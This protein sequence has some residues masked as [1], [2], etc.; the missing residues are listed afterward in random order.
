[1]NEQPSTLHFPLSFFISTFISKTIKRIFP[2]LPAGRQGSGYPEKLIAAKKQSR[3]KLIPIIIKKAIGA[4]TP[5][6]KKIIF[7]LLTVIFIS[8]A[9]IFFN[10][11]DKNTVVTPANGGT[12]MEGVIGTPR[13]INPIWAQIN[14]KE[15]DMD[16]ARL[17]FSSLFTFDAKG[18]LIND[19]AETYSI[20]DDKKTYTIKIKNNI[21][22]HDS[23][24]LASEIDKHLTA[25]DIL[26][27]I[28]IIQDSRYS[29]PLRGNLATVETEKIGDYEIRLSLKTPYEPFLQNLTFGILPQHL[30]KYISANDALFADYNRKPIG[31]G[32][33][34]LNQI[35][36]K[37]GSGIIT[38]IELIANNNYYGR[39]PFINQILFKFYGNQTDLLNALN[40]G[41][42]NATSYL[43]NENTAK[44]TRKNVKTIKLNTTQHS[45]VFFNQNN[46]KV[47]NDKDIRLALNYLTDK[48]QIIREVLL[49][50]GQRSNSPI[51]PVFGGYN[52]QTKDYA[53]DVPFANSLLEKTDWKMQE[54]G[55]RAQEIKEKIKDP[56]TK[57][58]TEV[59]KEKIPLE[60]EITVR[61]TPE[62][63]KTAG[64]IQNQW[65]KGGIRVN[66]KP[67][68]LFD[69]D[70]AIKNRNYD[71]ILF[72]ETLNI[73]P[74]PFI[75]WHS[76]KADGPGLNLAMY[77]NKNAD[78]F[79]ENYR[80]E[81]D[82]AKKK[83]FLD[84]FQVEVI[85]DAP[86]VF[87]FN[88]YLNYTI[89]D[90]IKSVDAKTVA[91]WN[92]RFSDISNWYIATK[93][94]WR[95]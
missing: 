49:G 76:S 12:L 55:F 10:F 31:S 30:W 24:Q 60:L 9:A 47:L 25:D 68:S 79:L 19:V 5:R 23:D 32:P 36:K 18:N 16:L 78:G 27:T 28:K 7:G 95:K 33:Y 42:I 35:T 26:F 56:K 50:N 2:D 41:Q 48:D 52:S 59:V 87:L 44:I 90:E 61:D 8:L 51:P 72:A 71:A 92:D 82:P 46:A 69:I 53:F 63:K 88:P 20:S 84:K 22:W 6:E 17:T 37:K 94:V 73:N 43:D 40:S 74:D 21:L 1:M 67:L 83:D 57:K 86:A 29:S 45:S 54:D 14:E 70:T 15:V 58:I 4:L 91:L 66:L 81:F 65:S 85:N 39:R 75:F 11:W 34:K 62:A 80:Q 93:R 38:S 3:L 77:T 89:A 13:Y 64:V